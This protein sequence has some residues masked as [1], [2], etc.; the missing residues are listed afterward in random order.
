[1]RIPA[2]CLFALLVIAPSVQAHPEVRDPGQVNK[3]LMYGTFQTPSLAPGETGTLAFDLH[4]PYVM[5][6]TNVVLNVSMYGYAEQD[7]S[8]D[9]DGSWRWEFPRFSGAPARGREMWITFSSIAPDE[10]N[11]VSLIVQTGQD[12]PHG[13][14]F[15]QGAYLI[16]FWLTF[17]YNGAPAHMASPGYWSREQFMYATEEGERCPASTGDCA[18]QVNLSRLGGIDG[19]LPDTAFGVKDDIPVWPMYTLIAGAVFFTFLGFLYYAEENPSKYPKFARAFAEIRGKA[20]RVFR[21][22]GRKGRTKTPKA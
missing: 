3:I 22:R 13:G 2:L 21:P 15:T 20:A 8:M 17:I 6:M 7:I 14:A 10:T 19:I 16:R 5:N 1:M 9:L 18:G 11:R 4:N 12:M